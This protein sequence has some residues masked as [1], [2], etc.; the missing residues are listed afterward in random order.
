MLLDIGHH[1]YFTDWRVKCSVK[2]SDISWLADLFAL[3]SV[4]ICGLINFYLRHYLATH[5]AVWYSPCLW[6]WFKFSWLKAYLKV[7]TPQFVTIYFWIANSKTQT[8][9]SIHM[10]GTILHDDWSY[11]ETSH[12]WQNSTVIC[13][14]MLTCHH[15]HIEK[16][17]IGC[18]WMGQTSNAHTIKSHRKRKTILRKALKHLL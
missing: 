2:Y 15:K 6:Y 17:K 9:T 7:Y 14:S 1:P 4:I 13:F 11:S 5:C 12:G 10:T 18:E 8:H 3:I 16:C